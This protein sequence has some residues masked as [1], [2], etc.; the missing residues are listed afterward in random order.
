MLY[1]ATLAKYPISNHKKGYKSK[2]PI[3]KCQSTSSLPPEIRADTSTN[4]TLTTGKISNPPCHPAP[5]PRKKASPSNIDSKSDSTIKERKAAKSG[6]TSPKVR[7]THPPKEA[8][9]KAKA[10]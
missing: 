10:K 2:Q 3:Q 6:P 9:E 5:A 8:N 4:L 7:S 1:P